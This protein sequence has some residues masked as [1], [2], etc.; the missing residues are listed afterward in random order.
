MKLLVHKMKAFYSNLRIKY[1]MFVLISIVMLVVSI[2]SLFVQQFAFKV[3]DQEI[4]QQ[5][6][7][8]LHLSSSGIE[9]ELK[10]MERLSYRIVTDPEIQNYLISLNRGDLQYDRF[11]SMDQLN[12]RLLDLGGLDKYIVS[13]QIFDGRGVEYAAGAQINRTPTER[14][15]KIK[16]EAAKRMGGVSWISPDDDDHALVIGREIR[17]VP[18]LDL[19]HLGTLAIRIDLEKMFVD[20]ARGLDQQDAQFLI[21]NEDALVYPD[22]ITELVGT[23]RN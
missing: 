13:L 12:E 16:L 20:F 2:I 4:Y 18:N 15:Q 23:I 1:K 11:V 21:M 17:A 3:Y 7:K 8:S 5:S 14:K 19:S 9:N 22:G 6:A 10:K